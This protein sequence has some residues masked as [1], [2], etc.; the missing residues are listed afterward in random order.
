MKEVFV[1]VKGYEGKY[2]I[3]D[4]RRIK[5]LARIIK[6]CDG[7]IRTIKER[8]IFSDKLSVGLGKGHGKN[9]RS[10]DVAQLMT[11]SFYRDYSSSKFKIHTKVPRIKATL[12][13][14]ILTEK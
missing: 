11:E 3:S 9:G 7:R 1:P 2:E 12:K 13:D 6:R 5:S 8:F 10:H 4:Q 14:I